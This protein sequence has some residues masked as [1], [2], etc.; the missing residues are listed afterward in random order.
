MKVLKTLVI[1]GIVVIVGG[2]FAWK[3][4][5]DL[6]AST[7]SKKM[8]VEVKINDISLSADEVTVDK[9]EIGNPKG[10]QLP[11]AFSA[12]S[13]RVNAPLFNY[14]RDAIIIDEIEVN[15]IY[16][17]LEVTSPV[18]PAGNWATIMDNLKKSSPPAPEKTEKKDAA[19]PAKSILIKKI[20]LTDI[21]ADLVTALSAGAVKKLAQ[22]ERLEFTDV[23]S[24]SGVSIDQIISLILEQTL[25]SVLKNNGMKN[26]MN[27]VIDSPEKVIDSVIKSPSGVLDTFT[28]P[29]K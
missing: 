23:S 7:L 24:D 12:G 18:S 25:T 10:S 22:I 20:I 4:A 28:S 1:L 17:S 9:L 15:H 21:N 19:E 6:I 5:P 14:A 3:M 8:Q 29:F 2:F 26:V 27:S 11:T 13:I 16:L